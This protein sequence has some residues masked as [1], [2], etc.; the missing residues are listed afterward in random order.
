MDIK[1]LR[2]FTN[3]SLFR[4]KSGSVIPVEVSVSYRK[5]GNEAFADAAVPRGCIRAA[6]IAAFAGLG[7]TVSVRPANLKAAG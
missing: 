6:A 1:K 2:S 7:A 4:D 3:E 5:L